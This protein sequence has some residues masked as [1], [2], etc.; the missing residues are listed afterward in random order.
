QRHRQPAARVRDAQGDGLRPALPRR[1][2]PAA[3]GVHRAARLRS[4][5]PRPPWTLRARTGDAGRPER[6]EHGAAGARASADACHGRALR[7]ARPAQGAIGRPRGAVLIMRISRRVPVAWLNLAHKK[8]RFVLSV[9]GI[10][11]AV[12]LMFVQLGFWRAL[13][14]SQT[15]ILRAVD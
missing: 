5:A 7:R 6:D 13:L 11:F 2:R 12:V 14:D 1:S 4:R 10:S 8:G 15:A 9:L 3:G